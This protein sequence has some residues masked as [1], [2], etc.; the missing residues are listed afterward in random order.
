MQRGD[1]QATPEA[2]LKLVDSGDPPLRLALGSMLLLSARA[3]YSDRIA[4]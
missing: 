3:L 1:P 2:I 4:T